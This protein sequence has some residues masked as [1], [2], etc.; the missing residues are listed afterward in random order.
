MLQV[1]ESSHAAEMTEGKPDV[2]PYAG[3]NNAILV[4]VPLLAGGIR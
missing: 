4:L 3:P 2:A 1:P